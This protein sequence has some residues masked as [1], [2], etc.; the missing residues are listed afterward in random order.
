MTAHPQPTPTDVRLDRFSARVNPW[1]TVLAI[2]WLPVL[3]VPFVTTLRG[4]VAATF[5]AF[6]YFVWFAFGVEYGIELWLAV[7][8]R[9]FVRNHLLDLAVVAVPILRPL[10]LARLFRLV[11][12]GRVGAVLSEGLNRSKKL[13]TSHGLHFVL[14]AVTVIILAAAGT[15]TLVER[16]VPGSTIHNFGD[17]LW[18]A[19]ETV[20]T[21]GYGDKVPVTGT[22]R[23]VAVI[24]MLTAI[25]LVG[26]L[27]ASVASYFV[28]EQQPN[29]ELAEVKA[30]LDQVL[31]L[32][33]ESGVEAAAATVGLED[34]HTA[35][36]LLP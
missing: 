7:D 30:K 27:T 6:D 28:K 36:G 2:A 18:W 21:V 16:H 32:L 5:E 24:L 20:T 13:L 34:V 22:G 33:G 4:A 9:H 26:F 3:I 29:G 11:R 14:L 10:R 12:L 23:I 8:K 19:M 17:A 1:M 31:A 25:G 15:E 35:E